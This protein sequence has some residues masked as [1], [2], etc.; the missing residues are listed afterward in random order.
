[1]SGCDS[2]SSEALPKDTMSIARRYRDLRRATIFGLLLV[3]L[4]MFHSSPGS[5]LDPFRCAIYLL[6]T[7]A[8]AVTHLVEQ[9]SKNWFR[10]DT[11]FLL[12]FFIVHYQQLT[13]ALVSGLTPESTRF[14]LPMQDHAT[15]G[16]WLSAIALVSWLI[17]FA[18]ANPETK[19]R[20]DAV[21]NGHWVLAMSCAGFAAFALFVDS[22]YFTA[23][24]YR[25]VQENF[26]QTVSGVSSYLLTMTEILTIILLALFFY[27]PVA[28]S[29]RFAQASYIRV[30]PTFSRSTKPIVALYLAVYVVAF[31][32]AGERGQVIQVLSAVGLVYATNIRAVRFHE[33]LLLAVLAAFVFTAIGIIRGVSLAD[34][35][36]GGHYLD[37]GYWA[38]TQNLAGSSITL[39]Q[40]IDLVHSREAFYWGQLWL[41]QLLGLVPFLQSAFLSMTGW[42]LDDISSASQITGYI[43]GNDRHTGYGTSFVVDMY[44]NFGVP[45]ILVFSFLYGWICKHAS[46]WLNGNAGFPKFV[47]A[48]AFGSLLF[49]VTRSS[50]LFQLRPVVWGLLIA[51]LLRRSP[52]S[53]RPLTASP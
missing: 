13:M 39:Y 28:N 25:T 8:A 49:Y 53:A 35:L 1:M 45:G 27:P 47:I 3:V 11:L 16:A 32:M 44:M 19:P 34:A 10:M 12:G 17:G 52:M 24:L 41:S 7:V 4:L 37:A 51:L 15:Y 26:Y 23:E 33:F 40:G 22:G 6:A 43:L 18:A 9:E 29:T 30:G 48:V 42:A 20:A 31:V 14:I 2:D 36:G 46:E 38:L 50:I 5:G 21:A